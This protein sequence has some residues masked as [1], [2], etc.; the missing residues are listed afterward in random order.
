MQLYNKKKLQRK[1]FFIIRIYRIL[2][3]RSSEQLQ[4]NTATLAAIS[5]CLG[6]TTNNEVIIHALAGLMRRT[7]RAQGESVRLYRSHPDPSAGFSRRRQRRDKRRRRET[8][9]PGGSLREKKL[10]NDRIFLQGGGDLML[11]GRRLQYGG[12]GSRGKQ[13]KWD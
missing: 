5:Y 1:N 3:K 2:P 4:H 7:E 13:R 10:H 9:C 11:F 12:G 6:C 8:I